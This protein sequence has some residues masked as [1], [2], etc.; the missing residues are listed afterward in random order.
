[1][2]FH[3][4]ECQLEEMHFGDQKLFVSGFAIKTLPQEAA[5]LQQLLFWYH[6]GRSYQWVLGQRAEV[7]GQ[8]CYCST[9]SSFSFP[10]TLLRSSPYPCHVHALTLIHLHLCQKYIKWCMGFFTT[11]SHCQPRVI[12]KWSQACLCLRSIWTMPLIKCFNLVSPE[13][14]R[15]LDWMV[16]VGPL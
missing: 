5:L 13:L 10:C 8:E 1:M 6:H 14:L 4:K 7:K 16:I 2:Q 11:G 15:Q 9:N 12:I 3:C